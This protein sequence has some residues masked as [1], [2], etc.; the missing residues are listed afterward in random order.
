[1]DDDDSDVMPAVHGST[2]QPLFLNFTPDLSPQLATKKKPKSPK[3][4]STYKVNGVNILNRYGACSP[5]NFR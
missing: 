4:A 2:G 3:K 5:N 1:M